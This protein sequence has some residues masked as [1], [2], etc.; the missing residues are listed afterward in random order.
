VTR[1]LVFRPEADEEAQSTRR[2]YEE[3]RPDL[4]DQFADAID[5]TIGRIVSN[6]L[7]FPVAHNDTRRAIVRG[8][9][10]G[11]YFR[12]AKDYVVVTAAMHGRRNPRR[13][14]GRR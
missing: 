11:V 7:A 13:W 4:G 2:W 10:Y 9:P 14:Q 6:P 8:F 5:E 1:K 12:L 3:Q